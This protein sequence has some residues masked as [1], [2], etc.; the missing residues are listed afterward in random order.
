MKGSLVAVTVLGADRPGL[1]ADITGKIADAGANILDIEQSVIRNLFSMFM[2]VDLSNT[3]VVA[4]EFSEKLAGMARALNVNITAAPFE[5]S[6]DDIKPGTKNLESI[7]IMGKDKP[8]IVAGISRAL[9]EIGINIER[10]KMIARGELLAMEMLID[11]KNKTSA[12]ELRARLR[13]A[14]EET[15]MDIVVQPRDN[16]RLRKRLIV[17]DMDSTIV[18][19]EIIDEIAHAAGVGKEVADITAS[20]MDGRMEFKESLTKRVKLL[21]GLPIKTLDDIKNNM[22]LTPGT[23]EL[24]H[25]LK[26]MGFKLALISGGFTY[27]TDELKNRLGFDYA[28]ANKLVIK[29]GKVT[30]EIEGE[31]ID[32]E[33]KAEILKELMRK[34]N[35][36]KEEVV[37]VG[38]GANDRIM[39]KNAGLGIA[40]NAKEVLKKA[41]DG[42]LT[43]NNLKGLIYCLGVSEKEM[44]ESKHA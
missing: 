1:V 35:I 29:D 24:L 10:I 2:L 5:G 3:G 6:A 37:A 30:G 44:N 9:Y 25:A 11:L 31:I 4:G 36:S 41:A 20:G 33:K 32:S 22:K 43:K 15:G 38:D 16:A 14:G 40:F 13:K 34:E 27:F 8:G 19:A 21:K 42:S 39:L 28:Y 17:F 7:T 26:N 18:D 23:G 12:E